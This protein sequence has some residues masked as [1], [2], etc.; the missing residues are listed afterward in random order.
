MKKNYKSEGI[1]LYREKIRELKMLDYM[2]LK[3]FDC[4]EKVKDKSIRLY[5]EGYLCGSV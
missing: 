2:R 3:V 4:I 1:R 5:R